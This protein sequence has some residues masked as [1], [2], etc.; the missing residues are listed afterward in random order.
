MSVLPTG[1]RIHAA[2]EPVGQAK[3]GRAPSIPGV[4]DTQ[5]V[6]W[7]QD[8]PLSGGQGPH[9][10]PHP[11]LGQERLSRSVPAAAF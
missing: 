5:H 4:S 3:D 7:K 8:Q 11:Q 1:G 10:Q 6:P 9:P 2:S